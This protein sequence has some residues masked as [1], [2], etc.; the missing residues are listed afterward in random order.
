[1][2]KEAQRLAEEAQARA[3]KEKKQEEERQ[4]REQERLKRE[5]EKRQKEEER[6]RKDEEK[7]RRLKEEKDRLMEKERKRKEKE[8][9]ERKEK[10]E[11][12]RKEAEEKQEQDRRE[13]ERLEALK[14]KE[15]QEQ[16]RK[17]MSIPVIPPSIPSPLVPIASQSTPH[18]SMSSSAIKNANNILK[19]PKTLYSEVDEKLDTTA[20][21]SLTPLNLSSVS[22]PLAFHPLPNSP[23]SPVRSP[24]FRNHLPSMP[25]LNA[26]SSLPGMETPIWWLLQT[27]IIP[28]TLLAFH[29][30]SFSERCIPRPGC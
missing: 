20:T 6:L 23:L 22:Q 9:K 16:K 27:F 1:M 8:E 15:L 24:S 13:K 14:L 30:S 11:R 28:H 18:Q 2:A 26:S 3:E 5:E 12:M 19:S 29:P 25:T 4:K 21:L 7:R 10:E 17:E